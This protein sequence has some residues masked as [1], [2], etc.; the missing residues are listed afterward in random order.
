M[1]RVRRARRYGTQDAGFTLIEVLV[2]VAIIALLASVLL[3]SLRQASEQAKQVKCI[4]NL[5]QLG[6]AAN[7]YLGSNRDRFCWGPLYRNGVF[8]GNSS[9]VPLTRTWYF[10]GNRGQSSSQLGTGG[11]Y[12]PAVTPTHDWPPSER[13][14][15]KYVYSGA[16][17]TDAD[18]RPL[19]QEGP[20]RIFQCPSDK[21]VRWNGDPNSELQ[22]TAT[23]YLEVGTSY[24][25]NNSWGYYAKAA[26]PGE[27][28]T[29]AAQAD[30]I[31]FLMDRIVKILLKKGASRAVLLYEDTADWALN[32]ADAIEAAKGPNYKVKSWHGKL[33]YA[34]FTFLDGHAAQLYVDWRV[35]KYANPKSMTSTWV[36]RQFYREN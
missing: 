34:N 6:K 21:G 12:D 25:S 18:R 29:G 22:F 14:M 27:G 11:Y 35:A 8:Q 1:N 5:G 7:M 28:Y 17:L 31:K 30:R 32:T 20:L 3:P 2:V 10:G 24:Q 4:A 19:R 13:P 33:N 16:K 9:G 15:N 36:V 26:S 23:A